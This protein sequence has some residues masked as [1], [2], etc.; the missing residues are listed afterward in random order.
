MSGPETSGTIETAA[1][2]AFFKRTKAL[3]HALST[4]ELALPFSVTHETLQRASVQG[5]CEWLSNTNG[6]SALSPQSARGPVLDLSDAIAAMTRV[7]TK[8]CDG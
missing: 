2:K 8:L 6:L 7:E 1:L 4:K 5:A 3:D